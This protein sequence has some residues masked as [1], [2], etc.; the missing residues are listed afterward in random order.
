MNENDSNN[1]NKTYTESDDSHEIN[2]LEE[3]VQE[4]Q[5]EIETLSSERDRI[6][7]ESKLAIE[8]AELARTFS[9]K[10]YSELL[11]E[12][13]EKPAKRLRRQTFFMLTLSIIILL[14][15]GYFST[16]Y[17][18]MVGK[19]AVEDALLNTQNNI[20]TNAITAD[21]I[22]N[23]VAQ[24]SLEPLEKPASQEAANSEITANIEAPEANKP[25]PLTEKELLIKKQAQTILNYVEN[26]QSQ[27]GFPK[28]YMRSKTQFAQLYL[29]VMQHSSS[30]SIYYEAYLEAINALNINDHVAPKTVEDLVRIDE[31]FL[32]ATYSGYLITSKKRLKKW[33][34]RETDK[35]FSSYYDSTLDYDLGAWQIVNEKD[36]YSLL[37]QAFLLNIE[38]IVQQLYFNGKTTRLSVP[39]QAHYLAYA[40]QG[41][42][43][44]VEKLVSGTLSGKNDGILT[45]D[46]SETP[47]SI[48]KKLIYAM[49]KALAEKGFISESIINGIAGPKTAAAIKAYKK[50]SG[51]GNNGIINLALLKNLGLSVNFSELIFN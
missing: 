51:T 17:I 38:R 26:A 12:L 50:S 36:D 40:E 3:L 9:R 39:A 14:V 29:I 11:N 32:Q 37:P 31:K 21:P 8:D 13:F 1:I 2:R 23:N 46:I 4:L 7:I 6:A 19:K 22:E 18:A 27:Q 48:N 49:Q 5:A 24:H 10:N 42:N 47:I 15:A 44:A 25:K 43:N 45:I 30:E 35:Q 34:Y 20:A 33:R 16:G 28:D 41:K